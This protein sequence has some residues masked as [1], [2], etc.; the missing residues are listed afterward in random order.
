MIK[1]FKHCLQHEAHLMPKYLEFSSSHFLRSEAS[2]LTIE[3]T[4]SSLTKALYPLCPLSP[5][6]NF[7][8]L[9]LRLF[10]INLKFV[11]CFSST[12][13][14]AILQFIRYIKNL[15]SLFNYCHYSNF[16]VFSDYTTR[17]LVQLSELLMLLQFLDLFTAFPSVPF[18]RY[19][20]AGTKLTTNFT[21]SSKRFDGSR[22]KILLTSSFIYKKLK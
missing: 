9:L 8:S 12:L 1:L 13:L 14:G 21:R 3:A 2:V 17:L 6:R 22:V 4:D 16:K 18:N 5:F 11:Y 15:P 7:L 19:N 20:L 10:L